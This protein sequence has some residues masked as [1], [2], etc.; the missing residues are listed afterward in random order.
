MLAKLSLILFLIEDSV[1]YQM[2]FTE[3]KISFLAKVVAFS[4][5]KIHIFILRCE[6]KR[7]LL[8]T[9]ILNLKLYLLHFL[10]K[11]LETLYYYILGNYG[12]LKLLVAIFEVFLA[13]AIFNCHYSLLRPKSNIWSI[14]SI[15]F[16]PYHIIT[17]FQD[18][19]SKT[20]GDRFFSSKCT[21]W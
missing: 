10:R 6:L 9:Y 7:H 19:S 17:K 20:V 18:L 12:I 2:L 8:R 21:F 11:G 14:N 5:L 1:N 13:L 4:N 15:V 3:S 16:S